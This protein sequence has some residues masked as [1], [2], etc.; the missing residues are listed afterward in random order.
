MPSELIELTELDV[1]IE[2]A[3]PGADETDAWDPVFRDLW[4]ATCTLNYLLEGLQYPESPETPETAHQLREAFKT[5]VSTTELA[6]GREDYIETLVEAHEAGLNLVRRDAVDER[7]DEL[8][9]QEA[10]QQETA[11]LEPADVTI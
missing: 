1:E 9:A 8:K 3:G 5:E 7:S 11:S 2:V 4:K 10:Q 6:Q